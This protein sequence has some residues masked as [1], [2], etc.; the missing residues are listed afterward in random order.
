MGGR[1][2][3][4][5]NGCREGRRFRATGC[6]RGG[7]KESTQEEG[8]CGQAKGRHG[9][10]HERGDTEGQEVAG[11]MPAEEEGQHGRRGQGD[12]SREHG[13]PEGGTGT[14]S[15]AAEAETVGYG[16]GNRSGR[17]SRAAKRPPVDPASVRHQVSRATVGKSESASGTGVTEAYSD[18]RRGRRQV[19]RRKSTG[20]GNTGLAMALAGAR[21]GSVGGREEQ[22]A[23]C[24]VLHGNPT[25]RRGGTAPGAWRSESAPR[26][27]GVTTR[28]HRDPG[29]LRGARQ[30]QPAC[31]LVCF[32]L[33]GSKDSIIAPM[34]SVPPWKAPCPVPGDQ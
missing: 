1:M 14:G 25:M 13:P 29:R 3:N 28:W 27:A 17:I 33:S 7:L 30:Y 8:G 9:E 4:Q 5:V 26:P 34:Q 19:Q 11:T 18:T 15:A 22:R 31:T 20:A 21:R 16:N 24:A 2:Q 12:E 23:V 32:G 10:G 6:R